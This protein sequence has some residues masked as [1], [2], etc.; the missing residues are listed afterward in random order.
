MTLTHVPHCYFR[1]QK[2]G[3][4][5]DIDTDHLFAKKRVVLFALP[6]AFTPTCSLK[7]L[8]GFESAYPD[9]IKYVDDV[10][11]L[12]VNDIFVM[13]EWFGSQAIKNVK[14]IPDGNGEFTYGMGMSVNKANLGF[15][16]RSWRYAMVV[17]K[18]QIEQI[19]EE[20]GKVG[21][22]PVDPYEVSTPENVLKWLEENS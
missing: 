10:Y 1:Y 4:W 8:P 18:G 20:P 14:P 6:G 9:L 11:C 16:F 7:Q 12:S 17:N 13:D 5:V 2:G 19:F 21:N 15:G 3:S 22:C